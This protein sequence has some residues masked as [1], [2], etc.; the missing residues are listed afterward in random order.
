MG[1]VQA[2][3]LCPRAVVVP[4]R[5]GE[6]AKASKAVFE[7]FRQTTPLVEGLSIDEA[8]L[9]VGGLGK[10]SGTPAE[11]A[12]RLRG[13]VRERPWCCRSS[14]QLPYAGGQ[15]RDGR[16]KR[17]PRPPTA[18]RERPEPQP[19]P[20]VAFD[21]LGMVVGLSWGNYCQRLWKG[22]TAYRFCRRSHGGLANRRLLR[23]ARPACQCAS[24]LLRDAMTRI[25]YDLDRFLR[26]RR[27]DPDD[28]ANG[29]RR[30]PRRSPAKLTS[31]TLCRRKV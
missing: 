6:Y 28:P 1:G 31:A 21:T 26:T 29:G 18:S 5:M 3:R 15:P 16:R 19:D 27:A 8:F 2:R 20:R 9:D 7:V 11:I 23:R 13:E 14:S 12:V 10:V 30:A 4:P 22:D 25:V 24:A 17:L